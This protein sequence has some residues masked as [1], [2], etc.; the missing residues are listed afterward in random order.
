VV[1]L[2]IW[3]RVGR[4]LKSASLAPVRTPCS[5]VPVSA[6][7]RLDARAQSPHLALLAER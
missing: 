6:A 2:G 4:D 1:G 3:I 7:I 5:F